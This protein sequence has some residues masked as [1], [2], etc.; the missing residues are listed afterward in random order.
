MSHPMAPQERWEGWLVALWCVVPLVP[1]VGKAVSIDGPVF[2]GV[3]HQILTH[4]LD[5]YGFQMIWDPT[6]P[7]VWVFNRNPPLLS[8][9]LAGWI[10]LFGESDTLLHVAMLPVSLFAGLSFLGIARR[11][12]GAGAGPA[13]LLV[14]TPAYF[15]LATTLMLDVL[16]LSFILFGVYAL[17]RGAERPSSGW[18]FVAGA[19]AAAAGLSKYVGF[20]AAPLLGVGVLLLYPRRTGPLLRVLA[21][22]LIIWGLWG[23]YTAHLYGT[24]HFAGSSDLLFGRGRFAPDEFWNHVCSAPVYYGCALIFPIFLWITGLLRGDHGTGLAVVGVIAGTL[25]VRFVLPDGE[26]SRRF[27]IDV[28]EATFGA[29]GCA[30]AIFLWGMFLRPSRLRE[31]GIDRFL[32]L[33]LSGVLF[34]TMFLNWHVNAADALMAAPAAILLVWRDPALRP[35]SRLL[36]GWLA[37]MMPLSL[38]LASA[39]FEQANVYRT[40]ARRI[41]AEIGERPGRRYFVGHWGLQ[42][43][44]ER[45]GFESIVPPHYGRS[46]LEVGDWVATARN[47][48]QL[49]VS[50]NMA[51][52][53]YQQVW[54]W[55]F[56][57]AIPLRTTNADASAGFYS[58]QTGYVPFAWTRK[59]LDTVTLGR[60]VAVKARPSRAR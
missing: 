16:V 41:A 7:D 34:F 3:A 58:H 5:P 59:P 35:G 29:L 48:S 10:R 15:V 32:L 40:A 39:D 44:L 27:P 36:A 53:D 38:L 49:D 42:H 21:P 57:T 31:R 9:Y 30:S 28:E 12:A 54:S 20:C 60:V 11:V 14:A 52:Y 47:V 25:V 51:E 19:A 50:R 4:P 18:P 26:P 1:F 37:L 17:L 2:L 46:D 45:E 56:A 23:V 8:Y 55:E 22:P 33:W 43:Y 24:P 13:L 6:S